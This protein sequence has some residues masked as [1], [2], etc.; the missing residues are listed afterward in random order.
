MNREMRRLQE[1]EE[2][3]QKKEGGGNRAQRKA[4]QLQS[5]SQ[6]PTERKR[7]VRRIGDYFH[8]VRVEMRKVTWPT[9]DQMKAFTAV[10]VITSVFL[11]AV[12]FGLDVAAKQGVLLLVELRN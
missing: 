7:L 4:S 12:I 10:T 5:R 2:R 8:E 3:R 9:W 1:R 6:A 11:T